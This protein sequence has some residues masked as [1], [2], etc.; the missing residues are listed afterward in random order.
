[1]RDAIR[2][3]DRAFIAE[4]RAVYANSRNVANRLQR[5]SGIAAAPLYH[6]PPLADRFRTASGEDFLFF[7]SRMNASKRQLLVV[8]AMAQCREPVRVCFAGAMEDPVYGRALQ[9]SIRDGG[10][11]DR[12]EWL[13]DVDDETKIDLFARCLAVIFP[14][15]DEDYGY[16][17]LE[18]MLAAKPVITCSDSGGV[19]EFVEDERTG[20][21]AQPSATALAE[22]MDRLWQQR[23]LA[24]E[25]GDAGRAAYQRR[26]ISWPR[27]VQTLTASA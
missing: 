21:I 11:A 8:A 10:L 9:D 23:A 27:V 7:P 24:E 13:G 14:P 26:D 25:W 1:V 16:V 22:A 15:V 20:L 6:P 4:A 5:F 12:I 2:A 19:L 17:T 3:A 18:A